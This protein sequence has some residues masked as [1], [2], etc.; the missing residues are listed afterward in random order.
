MTSL[1]H[2]NGFGLNHRPKNRRVAIDHK[3]ERYQLRHPDGGWLDWFGH[4]I[5][6]E[7]GRIY[8]ETRDRAVKMQAANP[9]A[10]QCTLELVQPKPTA[11]L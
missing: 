8:A 9:L 3:I 6:T 5:T 10:A 7:R 1:Q 4:R 11:R 2:D